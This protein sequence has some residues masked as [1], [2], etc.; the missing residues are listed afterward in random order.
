MSPPLDRGPLPKDQ[1][2]A[3]YRFWTLKREMQKRI[4]ASIQRNAP[5]E[6][7]VDQPEKESGVVRV[8]GPFTVEALRIPE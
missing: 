1:L 3:L 8:S 2:V 4:D 7:L 5:Q 6:E